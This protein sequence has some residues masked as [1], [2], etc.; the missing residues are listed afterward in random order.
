MLLSA[1]VTADQVQVQHV[2][3]GDTIIVTTAEGGREHVRLLGINTP[4]VRRKDRPGEPGGAA[5]R[6]WLKQQ[7]HKQSVRLESDRE[8]HDRYGRRLAHIFL[9]GQHINRALVAQGWATV[10]IVPPNL[11][12]T[13]VLLQAQ[14]QAETQKLGVWRLNTYQPRNILEVAENPGRGWQRLRGKVVRVER[15]KAICAVV[16]F[17]DLSAADSINVRIP[18]QWLGHFPPVERYIGQQVEVRGWVSLPKSARSKNGG[19]GYQSYSILMRHP[20]GLVI[21]AGFD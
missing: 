2:I 9:N 1:V 18:R 16:F 8:S 17:T 11:K 6:A 15:G 10:N 21:I 20:S 4:E 13:Q 14:H 3:D 19:A 12:Y 5:A 7:L